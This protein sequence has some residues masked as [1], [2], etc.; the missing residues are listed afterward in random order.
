MTYQYSY[1]SP[2]AESGTFPFAYVDIAFC[3]EKQGT[4]AVN[5]STVR[6]GFFSYTKRKRKSQPNARLY[7]SI[8]TIAEVMAVTIALNPFKK[9]EDSSH[10][11]WA[12]VQV[13]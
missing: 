7:Y 5:T 9:E 3:L 6:A 1:Q 2:V 8:R 11:H 10:L 4:T 12:H 13:S